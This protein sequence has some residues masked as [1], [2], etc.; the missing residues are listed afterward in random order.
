MKNHCMYKHPEKYIELMPASEKL[1]MKLDPQT[2]KADG[3]ARQADRDA[4]RSV[5]FL[6]ASQNEK[7]VRLRSVWPYAAFQRP[8]AHPA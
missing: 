1:E 3:A 7:K 4:I 6:A 8:L 2:N 5:P